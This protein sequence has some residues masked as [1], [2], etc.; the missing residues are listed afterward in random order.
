MTY[1]KPEPDLFNLA[2]QK[3]QLP[4]ENILHIADH[5]KADVHGAKQ[6]GFQACWFNDQKQQIPQEPK[7]N[8]LPDV[9]ITQLSQLLEMV[10]IERSWN[11]KTYS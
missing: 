2:K 1:S 9:E 5:L 10:G 7:A 4:A 8:P 6:C 11:I 3:L